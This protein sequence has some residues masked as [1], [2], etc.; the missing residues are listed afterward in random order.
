[1][2]KPPLCYRPIGLDCVWYGAAY[3]PDWYP[4]DVDT[5]LE[6]MVEAGFT[7]VRMAEFNWDKLEPEEGRYAFGWLEAFLD[8]IHARGIRVI[9]CTPTAAPP[10]WMSTRYP[11][12]LMWDAS[13]VPYRHG[14]RRHGAMAS[15]KFREFSRAITTAMA[16]HFR[17]H[18]A[19]VAWQTDNE[20]H[21]HA[22]ED[23][24]PA[25]EKA[26][27]EFLREKYDGSIDRLNEA[28]GT[29]YWSRSYADFE[30]IQTPVDYRPAN[31]QPAHRLDYFRFLSWSTTRFQK[32]QVDILRKTNPAWKVFHNGLFEHLDYRGAFSEDLDFLGYDCYPFFAPSPGE[33]SLWQ[34]FS[35]DTARAW[36]GNFL[37]PET[38]AN[39]GGW[40]E[41]CHDTPEP[42]EIRRMIYMNLARGAEGVMFWPWRTSP[43]SGESHWRG[44]LDQD[45]RPGRAFREI[46]RTGGELA[47]FP[48][49]L[50]HARVCF[51]VG[52]AG[53]IQDSQEA[54]DA[55][56]LG[57][58]SPRKVAESLHG[59]L[60][61]KGVSVGV[62]HPEDLTDA[63]THYIIPH[64][65][66]LP[67]A[68]IPA[69]EKWVQEGGCLIVGAM[70]AT[71]TPQNGIVTV[72]R[73]GALAR[74][75]GVTVEEFGRQ[76]FPEDRP[77]T[78]RSGAEETTSTEWYE[79]LAPEAETE[80]LA[81]WDSR[82][83]KG[84]PAVTLRKTG[85]GSACYVGTWLTAEMLG[86]LARLPAM[87]DLFLPAIPGLDPRI[88]FTRRQSQKAEYDFLI[89]T[90]DEALPL[91]AQ[92]SPGEPLVSDATV[93]GRIPPHGIILSKRP[94]DAR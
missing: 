76:N 90:S 19:V 78:V 77:L 69:I 34:A 38:H 26:F 35:L 3:Y 42:G 49:D 58:P 88:F 23:H 83:L 55:Y 82:H 59:H 84:L 33:R 14:S 65:A 72:P 43:G 22:W 6:R 28:W 7:H 4:E 2:P 87:K 30:Q 37:V 32:E 20:F 91:S 5:D 53:A 16:E 63:V 51:R 40:V 12:I 70:S 56:S 18:P 61:T 17:R 50:N 64:M 39:G 71:R 11:E 74:L 36:R 85:K 93:E 31:C 29:R 10:A 73:P 66:L 21:C 8:R 24:S 67:D 41:A 86:F 57:L 79:L 68:F 81:T 45:N 60:I 92:L 89:N 54:H 48:A 15:D 1:M 9:L 25:A 75:C 46:A 13:G 44:C 27:R 47:G 62:L 80:T 52:I 94:R